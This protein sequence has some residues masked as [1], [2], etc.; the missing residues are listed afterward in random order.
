MADNDKKETQ[1][2]VEVASS[3]DAAAKAKTGFVHTT[4]FKCIIVLLIIVIVC[5]VF[6]AIFNALF[7]V[8][9]QERTDRAAKKIYGE[10]VTTIEEE[11]DSSVDVG[12]ATVNLVYKIEEYPNDYLINVTGKGGYSG[13]TVTCYVVVTVSDDGE[14]S[15]GNI[16]ISENDGQSFISN[17][18]SS[19]LEEF[20]KIYGTETTSTDEYHVLYTSED[21]F[22]INMSG[23]TQIGTG[24]SY[25]WT[26]VC[27]AVNAAISYVEQVYLHMEV[28]S[29]GYS[30]AYVYTD[31]I[32]LKKTSHVVSG[33]D[34]TYTIVTTD[35]PQATSFTIEITVSAGAT[36]SSY[37]I[38]T[39]G[40][41]GSYGSLMAENIEETF[42]GM[43]LDSVLALI[44]PDGGI[45]DDGFNASLR[46]GASYSNYLCAY[47]ALFAVANYDQAI[48]DGSI[49]V[50][51]EE[52]Y[53]DFDFDYTGFYFVDYIDEDKTSFYVIGSEVTYTVVTS[54]Y[55][56]A[57]P[58]TVE[59]TVD[60][61]DEV[62]TIENYVIKVDGSNNAW[63]E[64]QIKSVQSKYIGMTLEDVLAGM[65][66]SNG[67][68][69][70]TDEI[71]GS[72]LYNGSSE[73][74]TLCARAALFALANHGKIIEYYSDFVETDYINITKTTYYVVGDTV[75]YTVVTG[76]FENA[77]PFTVEVVVGYNETKETPEIISLTVLTDGSNQAWTDGE[78]ESL[79]NNY[80]G[81][82]MA[83]INCA[84]DTSGNLGTSESSS[85]EESKGIWK[86]TL[87]ETKSI[88]NGSSESCFLVAQAAYFALANYEKIIEPYKDYEAKDYIN[89]TET[90]YEVVGNEV[91]FTVVTGGFENAHPF[92]V[93]VVV[94]Y[95]ETKSTPEIISLTVL[96]DGSNQAWTDSEKESLS[97][98]YEGITKKDI[99]D[100]LDVTENGS[101][102]VE[103]GAEESKGIWK[104]T[105]DKATSIYNG[106]SES[107]FL[108]AQA[109]LFALC[110]YENF[111]KVEGYESF[112]AT[113]YINLTET[114]F[115]VVGD[116]VVFEVVTGGFRNAHPFTVEVVVGYL[117][118]ET[119]GEKTETVGIISLSVKEDG[120]N[121]KWT[122]DQISSLEANYEGMTLEEIKKC[123]DGDG[124]I[125]T[126]MD[127]ETSIYN[128]STES[129]MLV[130]QAALF[131]L[132]NYEAAVETVS[133]KY[134]NFEYTEY[135]N[136]TETYWVEN[137]DG[138]VTYTVVTGTYEHAH[139]FTV[140][141]TVGCLTDEDN[142]TTGT[143]CVLSLNVIV[144]GS[145]EKWSYGQK[146]L[147]SGNYVGETLEDIE[148]CFIDE[149]YDGPST[150]S[151][152]ASLGVWKGELDETSIYN[153]SSESCFLVAQAALFA[154][155]NF[156]AIVG[157]GD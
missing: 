59:I 106:S 29:S 62:P 25:S 130:A 151:G 1:T 69:I 20:A 71:Y 153:G 84:L 23:S 129:G 39:N 9:D 17:I 97:N 157:S 67:E 37:K 46:T 55:E 74:N 51:T 50:E 99:E 105:L 78:K 64:G 79:S 42:I 148:G 152:E 65:Q 68:Y 85:G 141:I 75:T 34:V 118:D 104:D 72:E 91:V 120:S 54:T 52:E 15:L 88:Y 13:G 58:F 122:D 109:A 45:D 22:Y 19:Y 112:G 73:S 4:A 47:A 35:Y 101:G 76:G 103:E 81:V 100:A 82:T 86:D 123:F 143:V 147:L 48:A 140:E 27:N 61:V 83:D 145:N 92:T 12:N 8:T 135:I 149:N 3:P 136:L 146:S 26:A 10:K 33:T 154:L 60:L 108:V 128:G 77:H 114:T 28:A 90:T 49:G 125:K 139:P 38:V 18:K 5:S 56:N 32:N 80:V 2:E 94:G 126:D 96:T 70:I 155:A 14:I 57:H 134:E 119:T 110:N 150:D 133:E 124:V 6:L 142:E 115:S 16:T 144:D 41:T 53:E 44:N 138:T 132:T 137:D 117:T 113:D 87:D 107:C 93:E 102:S 30:N 95:N 127:K 36:I 11:V 131:A 111:V 89:L 121:T 116:S 63:S 156:E 66:Y 98:N 24:A 31:Y 7:E 43:G 40:S 21:G